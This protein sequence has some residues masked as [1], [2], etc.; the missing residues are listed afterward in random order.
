MI[1]WFVCSCSMAI[2][3]K[4][5]FTTIKFSFPLCLTAYHF[6]VQGL[7]AHLTVHSG[8]VQKIPVKI[9]DAMLSAY[10][11]AVLM[12]IEVVFNNMGLKYNHVSFVQTLRSLTPLCAA[13]LSWIVLGKKLRRTPAIAL[14]PVCIGVSI[15]TYEEL[16][17]HLG[18]FLA[19]M[20]SCFLTAG[21]LVTASS[22]FEGRIK[23]DA[24]NAVS[25]MAP[26]SSI[27]VFPV[28]V[29]TEGASILAWWGA[30]GVRPGYSLHLLFGSGILAF[31]LNVSIFLLLK[32][33]GPVAVAVAGNLKV[34][35]VILTSLLIFRNPVTLKGLLGCAV[36]VAGCAWYGSIKEKFLHKP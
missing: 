23:L 15:S 30:R 27:A 11:V 3:N 34:I 8:F 32:S 1:A 29:F 24:I 31:F 25:I 36:A 2:L 19:V 21:R 18:G 12:G 16:S 17:F 4:Y 6:A 35:L 13:L 5:I 28:A 7:L 9:G 10:P 20:L 14:I 33:T 26:V 22:L